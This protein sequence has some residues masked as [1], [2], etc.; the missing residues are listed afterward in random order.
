LMIMVNTLLS[1]PSKDSWTFG[2]CFSL[3][4]GHSYRLI[5]VNNIACFLKC[6]E[7]KAGMRLR[8][9]KVILAGYFSDQ[10][11]RIRW[12][13]KDSSISE[14]QFETPIADVQQLLL[15]PDGKTLYLRAGSELYVAKKH[16]DAFIIRE[17]VDL[18]QGKEQHAV[19]DIDLLSGAY[20]LL[21]T[22]QDGL[23][24]QWFDV[25]KAKVFTAFI[26]MAPCKVT[27]PRAKSW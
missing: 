16:G 15:T 10:R 17:I 24:S 2:H 5:S 18:S 22:H 20:S 9:K 1:S 6:P 25:L 12:Q 4:S 27:I 14:F 7:H 26:L 23:V 3:Q 21:V 19:S 13:N 8:L 11:V